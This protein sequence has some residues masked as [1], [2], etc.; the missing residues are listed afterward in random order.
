MNGV[1]ENREETCISALLES[2]N[3]YSGDN[4]HF[5]TNANKIFYLLLIYNLIV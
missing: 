2:T 3:T 5:Q 1:R 4:F